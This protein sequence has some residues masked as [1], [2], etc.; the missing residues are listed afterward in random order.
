M[1]KKVRKSA[2]RTT[3]SSATATRV[4][5]VKSKRIPWKSIA[6]GLVMILLSY[7]GLAAYRQNCDETHDL[8]VIGNGTPTVVQV[9]DPSCPS[10]RALKDNT[11]A[12]LKRLGSGLQ[13]RIA[14]LKTPEGRV[15]AQ[16]FQVGKITLLIFDGDG[17]M[18][19]SYQGVK[20]VDT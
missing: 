4:R 17:E 8:S 7:T 14:S 10:C 20:S 19:N 1:S 18:I 16:R 12:G 11:Q 5:T 2:K 15:L 3:T 13:Y 6:T 9:H